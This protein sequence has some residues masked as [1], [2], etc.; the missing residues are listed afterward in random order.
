MG[1]S[2][3]LTRLFYKLSEAGIIKPSKQSPADVF[4]VVLNE[5]QIDYG[6]EISAL[7][8]AEGIPTVFYTEP[9]AGK[10]KGKYAA[11]MGFRYVLTIGNDEVQSNTVAL[12]DMET[13]E[14][15]SL[16]IHEFIRSI[17]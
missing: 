1:I 17:H 13:G 15:K 4:V 10:K 3:G 9:N 8:R 7:L 12:K 16:A 14:A 5:E 11:R 6:L 2:I